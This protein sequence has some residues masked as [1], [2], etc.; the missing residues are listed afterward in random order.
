MAAGEDGKRALMIV[1]QFLAEIDIEAHKLPADM[2][3]WSLE[4]WEGG[5]GRARG[6]IADALTRMDTG[7]RPSRAGRQ[8]AGLPCRLC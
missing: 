5:G 2:L 7:T 4:G 6:P 3:R 8:P 1:P